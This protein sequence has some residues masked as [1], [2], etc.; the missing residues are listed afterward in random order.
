MT[1]KS[2]VQE[3]IL[4]ACNLT[5]TNSGNFFPLGRFVAVDTELS[6]SS[7]D[8]WIGFLSGRGFAQIIRIYST[9]KHT[10][11][12]II[13]MP[14]ALTINEPISSAQSMRMRQPQFTNSDVV[15][16]ITIN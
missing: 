12:N 15:R 4:L 13:T 11:Q 10:A 8:S 5:V 16:E 6:T 2:I 1:G 3:V 9:T 14:G 7:K